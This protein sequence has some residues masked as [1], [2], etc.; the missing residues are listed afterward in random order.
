MNDREGLRQAV[1]TAIAEQMLGDD[2][3]QTLL[4]NAA[5]AAI[6]A[7]ETHRPRADVVLT[8]GEWHQAIRRSYPIHPDATGRNIRA[9]FPF[10][11][12]EN[13]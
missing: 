3:L 2:F 12:V 1:T 5:D 8:Q 9:A 7:Y 10:I 11:K 13:E 6:A 4:E